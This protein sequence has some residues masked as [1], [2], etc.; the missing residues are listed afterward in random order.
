MSFNSSVQPSA[1]SPHVAS[2]HSTGLVATA[3]TTG[4]APRHP[5]GKCLRPS[6]TSKEQCR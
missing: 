6:S 1:Q 5:Q 4:H 2:G 3:I